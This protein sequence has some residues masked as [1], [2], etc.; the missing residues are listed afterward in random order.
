MAGYNVHTIT[1]HT[2]SVVEVARLTD[3]DETSLRVTTSS[4]DTDPLQCLTLVH[5]CA[6]TRTD[7][8]SKGQRS[9]SQATQ[10]RDI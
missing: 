2:L 9:R 3:A 1:N 5:V 6:T 8:K 7:W 4:V 10:R